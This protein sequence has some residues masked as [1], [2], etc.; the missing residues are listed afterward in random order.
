[1]TEDM[2]SGDHCFQGLKIMINIKFVKDEGHKSEEG[3]VQT[4]LGQDDFSKATLGLKKVQCKADDKD[5]NIR[6]YTHSSSFN[7]WGQRSIYDSVVE[8][9]Y[10][11][12][13]VDY[14]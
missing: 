2:G 10:F 9:D 8:L 11:Q 14:I 13:K 6:S 4:L 12:T 1:M 3:R 7:W 5:K